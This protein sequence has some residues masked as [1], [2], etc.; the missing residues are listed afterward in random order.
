MTGAEVTI[1]DDERTPTATLALTPATIDES[2]ATN[3]STV[4]ATLSA[5]S[6]EALTLTVSA[7]AGVTVSDNKVLTIA[8]GQ[9]ASAAR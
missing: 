7:G 4:T 8:A 1:A 9:A 2:G 3:V 5:A 6:S